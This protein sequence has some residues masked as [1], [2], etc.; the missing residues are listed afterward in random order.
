MKKITL[1]I[2][3]LLF[4]NLTFSQ[5]YSIEE[6]NIVQNLFG[7]QKKAVYEEN[8]DLSGVNADTFW[9]LYNEYEVERKKIG[10]KKVE[11][12]MS[13]TTAEGAVTNDQA[14]EILGKAANIRNSE[15]N[16]IM[17]FVKKMR[18]ETNPLVAAQFYQIEHYITDG[19][20]FTLLNNI[21]FIHKKE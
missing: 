13:Y 8:M 16:L 10:E 5:D 15:N 7:V 11:L 6:I 20:R 14:D 9:K 17:R 18:K 1:L 4:I 19:V 12:L 3:A 21:D 2:I